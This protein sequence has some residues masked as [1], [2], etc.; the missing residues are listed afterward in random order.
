MTGDSKFMFT[1]KTSSVTPSSVVNG[2]TR[3]EL[4]RNRQL[5]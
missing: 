3:C 2:V 5:N 4:H 1:E